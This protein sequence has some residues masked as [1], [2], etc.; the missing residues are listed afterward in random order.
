V[1]ALAWCAGAGLCLAVPDAGSSAQRWT[2]LAVGG[3][4][5]PP[6]PAVP[7]GAFGSA[8]RGVGVVGAPLLVAAVL[9]R[10]GVLLATA[11]AIVLATAAAR[12][13]QSAGRRAALTVERTR[14]DAIG[15]AV[16]ELRAGS[17]PGRA[18]RAAAVIDPGGGWHAAADAL[19]ADADPAEVLMHSRGLAG[20]GHAWRVAAQTGAPLADVLDRIAVDAAGTVAHRRAVRGALAGA[21]ASATVLAALPLLGLAL[22]SAM[23]LHPLET[24]LHTKPGHLL[25]CLGALLEAAGVLWTARIVTRAGS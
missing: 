5:A 6:P 3:R 25:C 8:V 13:R 12:W 16:A 21:H 22:G 15:L 7:A 9:L 20:V 24:L 23:G 17:R 2:R 10:E 19:T 14:A 18:L 4:L 11:A 1:S